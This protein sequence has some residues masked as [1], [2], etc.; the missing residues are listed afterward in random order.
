MRFGCHVQVAG[1]YEKATRYAASV[2]CEC[3]QVFAKSPRMWHSPPIDP[4]NAARFVALREELGIRPLF[5]HTAYLINLGSADDILWLR[6]VEALADEL[7]RAALLHADGV[8]T[9]IGTRCAEETEACADRV[10]A[11]VLGAFERA[12]DEVPRLLLENTAGAGRSFG[13]EFAEIGLTLRRLEPAGVPVGICLDTCHAHAFGTDLSSAEGW[14]RALDDLE[15]TCG[16]GRLR[17]IH[18]N[19]S[20]MAC[21]SHRDRHAWV[22]D[23][24][25]GYDGF[26]AM[27]NEPRL[28]D[29]PVVTEM[30]GEP[31]VKDEENLRRLRR[32][33]RNPHEA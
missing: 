28:A 33:R 15:A 19:D 9:H 23:G 27:V 25:I 22:G 13:G 20:M 30:P 10:A 11:G 16:V 29:V 5:V 4:S 8:V 31:P 26:A 32:L 2:G 21:G 18:G 12:G 24:T 17:L 1:G 6:S 7:R 14:T 3:M